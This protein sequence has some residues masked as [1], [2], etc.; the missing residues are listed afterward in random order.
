M[1]F[2]AFG[3]Y[4]PKI[5]EKKNSSALEGYPCTNP[6]S[7]DVPAYKTVNIFGSRSAKIKNTQGTILTWN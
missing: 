4:L 3:D 7:L 5:A 2:G 1:R 6:G